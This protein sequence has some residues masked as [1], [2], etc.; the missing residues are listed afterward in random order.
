[1]PTQF[2]RK[3]MKN[4]ILALFLLGLLMVGCQTK[5]GTGALVGGGLGAATGG[6]IG[7]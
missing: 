2:W 1:M 4:R 5:T 7:G 6:A 3:I